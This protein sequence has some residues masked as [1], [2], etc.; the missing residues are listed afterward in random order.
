MAFVATT[1][2]TNT[3][4]AAGKFGVLGSAGM[5]PDVLRGPI[6]DIRQA[7]HTAFGV[8]IIPRF[9]TAEHVAVYAAEK[10]PVVVFYWDDPA[11]A[12]SASLIRGLWLKPRRRRRAP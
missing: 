11:P 3:V 4:C 10:V 8:N 9:C 5:P 12:T 2:L 1:P 6:R 7:G